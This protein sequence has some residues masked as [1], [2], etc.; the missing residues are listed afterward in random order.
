MAGVP[1]LDIVFRIDALKWDVRE[2][3][4]FKTTFNRGILSLWF[5]FERD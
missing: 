3:K 2:H 4:G 5:N 1:Y